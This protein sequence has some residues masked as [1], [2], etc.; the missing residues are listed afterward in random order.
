MYVCVVRHSTHGFCG[1]TAFCFQ[2][3]P[4]I[5][6]R[7]CCP[8]NYLS[9]PSPSANLA[10]PLSCSV[11]PPKLSLALVPCSFIHLGLYFP[12]SRLSFLSSVCVHVGSSSVFILITHC[13]RVL[14]LLTKSDSLTT[15]YYPSPFLRMFVSSC[16]RSTSAFQGLSCLIPSPFSLSLSS[17]P[18]L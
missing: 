15:L 2:L 18:T 7:F 1:P 6:N 5:A 4:I 9:L 12:R 14:L 17:I 3:K 16:V 13:P 11:F 10:Y 8:S